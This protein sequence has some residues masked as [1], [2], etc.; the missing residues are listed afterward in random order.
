M[1]QLT[2]RFGVPQ[3]DL[4]QPWAFPMHLLM[5]QAQHS[6]CCHT[7][8]AAPLVQS[9]KS[10]TSVGALVKGPVPAVAMVILGLPFSSCFG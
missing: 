10:L 8:V 4:Q 2:A 7:V 9:P 1:F 5:A 6:L 3:W